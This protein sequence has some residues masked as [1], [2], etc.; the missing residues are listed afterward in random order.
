MDSQSTGHRVCLAGRRDFCGW[1]FMPGGPPSS[2]PRDV[3]NM[4]RTELQGVGLAQVWE[5]CPGAGW[6]SSLLDPLPSLELIF[7]PGRWRV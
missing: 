6:G 5:G 4:C 2:R 1:L 3:P 7:H